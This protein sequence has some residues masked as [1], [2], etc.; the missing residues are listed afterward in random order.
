LTYFLQVGVFPHFSGVSG[1]KARVV[2]TPADLSGMQQTE[3]ENEVPT[4]TIQL[5]PGVV[6][7]WV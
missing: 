2:I 4:A 7:R 6:S 1:L 5:L 3:Q